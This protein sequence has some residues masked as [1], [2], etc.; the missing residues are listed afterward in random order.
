M[1]YVFETSDR[2]GKYEIKI[3]LSDNRGVL[4]TN[5]VWHLIELDESNPILTE[6]CPEILHNLLDNLRFSVSERKLAESDM[7]MFLAFLY[8]NLLATMN[9]DKNANEQIILENTDNKENK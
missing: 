9:I 3:T 7:N 2:N 5:S 8:G 4:S 1:R 6:E